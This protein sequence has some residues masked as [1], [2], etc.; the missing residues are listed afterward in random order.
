MFPDGFHTIQQAPESPA[1]GMRESSKRK[2]LKKKGK[3]SRQGATK[4]RGRW[5]QRSSRCKTPRGLRVRSCPLQAHPT[6][7]AALSTYQSL[8]ISAEPWVSKKKKSREAKIR[9]AHWP[10]K[11]QVTRAEGWHVEGRL[12]RVREDEED[13]LQ[14][15]HSTELIKNRLS[16]Q[17]HTIR[18]SQKYI[19]VVSR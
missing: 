16:R 14:E 9:R 15:G 13:G 4:P 2:K 8:S 3:G 6:F 19:K 18:F 11:W 10:Q 1:E 12:S 17:V 5:A 7:P